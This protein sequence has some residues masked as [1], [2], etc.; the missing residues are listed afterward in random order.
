MAVRVSQVDLV[1]RAAATLSGAAN[2]D[3]I[4]CRGASQVVFTLAATDAGTLSAITFEVSDDKVNILA[5]ATGVAGAGCTGV[6]GLASGSVTYNAAPGKAIVVSASS[7]RG[8]FWNFM[9]VVTTPTTTI[10]NFF[11]TGT[12][13]DYE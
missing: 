9:R 13:Y 12:V 10:A 2:S 3:W 7:H 4:P 1:L 11:I 5:N 6:T 8:I